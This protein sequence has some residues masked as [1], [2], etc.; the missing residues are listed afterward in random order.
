MKVICNE[1]EECS[2]ADMKFYYYGKD[3]GKLH[4]KQGYSCPHGKLHEKDNSCRI[5]CVRHVNRGDGDAEC[6][7]VTNA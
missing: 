2:Y 6:R 1:A 7:C 3:D 5:S 4:F